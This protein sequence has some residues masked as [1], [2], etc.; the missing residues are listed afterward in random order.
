ML[1]YRITEWGEPLEAFAEP[2]PDPQGTEVLLRVEACGVCHSDLHIWDGFFDMGDGKKIT[3][4]ERGVALPFTMGHEIVGEVVALGPD[5]EGAE[6]GDKRVAFPWIGCRHC[7][8]CARGEDLMCLSPQFLGTRVHGGYSDHVMVPHPKY[9]IDYEGVP[10]NLACTYACAGITAYSALKKIAPLDEEDYFV[11]IGAGGVG[12]SAVHIAR[13]M[14]RG[15]MIVADIDG[16]KRAA[17]RQAGAV[18]TIDNSAP[19]AIKKL[20]ELTGGGAAATLDFVGAPATSRFGIDALRKGGTHVVVGLYGDALPLSLP[21]FPFKLM[22]MRGSYT[23]T[24]EEMGELMTLVKAGKVPPIPVEPRPLAEATRTLT[25]LRE[26]RI[27]GR[28]V[29]TA[30]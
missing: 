3:L 17:A 26:G 11:I 10:R 28:V 5:A 22:T 13:A 21:L 8:H 27:L 4:A 14:L 25:D 29:L 1:S 16:T 30:G 15:K 18:E 9:L 6:I 2:T 12:L 19:D 7:A 23:G 20:R 24:L